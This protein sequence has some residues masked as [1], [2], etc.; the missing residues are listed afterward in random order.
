MSNPCDY[1]ICNPSQCTDECND[2]TNLLLPPSINVEGKKDMDRDK[3]ILS[4]IPL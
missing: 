3:D 2:E 1:G 4:V